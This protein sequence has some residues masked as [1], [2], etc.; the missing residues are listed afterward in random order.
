MSR[1]VRL[2]FRLIQVI[3]LNGHVRFLAGRGM[4]FGA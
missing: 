4:L 3:P 2:T 1:V